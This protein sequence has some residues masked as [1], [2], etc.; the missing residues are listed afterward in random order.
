M[1]APFWG[2]P[3]SNMKFHYIIF[4]KDTE[5]KTKC[6]ISGRVSSGI[7]IVRGHV[8]LSSCDEHCLNCREI[9]EYDSKR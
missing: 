5:Y 2:R 9:L 6:G 4:R 8:W 7:M 3:R 1:K